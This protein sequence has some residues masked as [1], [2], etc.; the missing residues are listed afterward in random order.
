VSEIRIQQTDE[1][2][3]RAACELLKTRGVTISAKRQK[4]LSLAQIQ[5]IVGM[6]PE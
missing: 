6:I 2:M 5:F 4:R 3:K 1:E